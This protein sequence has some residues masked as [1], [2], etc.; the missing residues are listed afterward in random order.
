M[1]KVKWV[2]FNA[3]FGYLAYASVY[4][5]EG[6]QFNLFRFIV[7]VNVICTIFAGMSEEVK[8][9]L[10]D[11]YSGIP[12]YISG[13]FDTVMIVFLIC[14]GWFFTGVLYLIQ[15]SVE[16]GVKDDAKKADTAK[17]K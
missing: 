3:F 16:H 13:T 4:G 9:V 10:T 15:S 1:K 11:S 6:W 17:A 2:L 5:G 14:N 8:K 12:K 7:W